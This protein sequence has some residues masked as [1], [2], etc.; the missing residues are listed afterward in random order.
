VGRSGGCR[1]RARREIPNPELSH[2]VNSAQAQFEFA[3]S[4]V[5]LST[6]SDLTALDAADVADAFAV[7]ARTIGDLE[8]DCRKER[9]DTPA[10]DAHTGSR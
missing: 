5:E 9:A 4:T 10:P 2:D 1:R 3:L 8:D 6:P 7:Y